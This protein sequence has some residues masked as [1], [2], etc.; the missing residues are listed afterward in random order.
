VKAWD[1]DWRAR[2]QEVDQ[3]LVSADDP[4]EAR[5]L[6]VDFWGETVTK[7]DLLLREMDAAG[8]PAV[9]GGEGLARAY[10]LVFAKT[11]PRCRWR[12]LSPWRFPT[13]QSDFPPGLPRSGRT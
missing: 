10:R 9:R 5:D 4:G 7:T 11:L 8:H 2:A 3:R 1:T 6:Y 13:T 12:A